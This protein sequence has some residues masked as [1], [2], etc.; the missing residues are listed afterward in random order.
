MTAKEVQEF[1]DSFKQHTT[2]AL[3]EHQSYTNQSPK[4]EPV[5]LSVQIACKNLPKN[6]KKGKVDPIVVVYG[7]Q[8]D[9]D[10]YSYLGQTEV[11]K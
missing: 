9:E 2:S 11:M 10:V 3:K 5:R 8:P 7:M 1:D 4:M 6:N